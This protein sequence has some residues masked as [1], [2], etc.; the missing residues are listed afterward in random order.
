MSKAWPPFIAFARNCVAQR[1]SVG[2]GGV[3]YLGACATASGDLD[4]AQVGIF[5]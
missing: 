2:A 3:Y 1:R 5:I 4:V